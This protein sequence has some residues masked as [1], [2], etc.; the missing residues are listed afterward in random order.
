MKRRILTRGILF[1]LC[2][3]AV[4]GMATTAFA[5]NPAFGFQLQNTGNTF[6]I[7]SGSQNSKVYI[8]KGWTYYVSR[9]D[10]PDPDSEGWAMAPHR[11]STYGVRDGNIK[12]VETTNSAKRTYTYNSEVATG[13]HRLGARI[14]NDYYP[15]SSLRLYGSWN[16]D[17]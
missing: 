15:S 11:G 1:V 9:I 8:S 16:A 10:I 2:L 3:M 5:V 13:N 4:F 17:T 7:D 12:W 6:M 14:D